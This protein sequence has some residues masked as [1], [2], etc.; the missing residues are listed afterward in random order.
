MSKLRTFTITVA[1]LAVFGA[2]Y[3]ATR[4]PGVENA[5]DKNAL[6]K[7]LG[8]GPSNKPVTV[9]TA[10]AEQR[11]YPL[12]LSANGVISALNTVDVR[13]QVNSTVSKVHIKEGQFVR[14]GELL[15]TLDS[16]I[17]EVN[18]AK[19]QA[20]LDKDLATLADNLR[21]LERNKDLFS[22]KF[23]AQSMVDASQTAVQAQQAVIAS[24]KA[25]I[26]AARVA[27]GYNKILAPS[28]GRTGT[29]NVFA[30]SS[31]QANASGVALVTITQMDPIAIS[32]PLPQRNLQDA[33][34][35]M[36]RSDSFVLARLP[37]EQSQFKG[38]LQFVDN[39]VDAASGTVKVKALFENKEMKLWPGAYANVELSVLTL[40]DAIVVPQDGIIIG[41][42]ENSVYVVDAE[43][44]AAMRKVTLLHSYG[45][46]AVVSG[47]AAG[48]KVILDGKQNL[49][50]GMQVKERVADAKLDS[51]PTTKP[52]T[53][54]NTKSD[55]KPASSA[56][57]VSAS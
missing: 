56:A 4:T 44:K 3:Y 16:R 17:D 21:N 49:R 22:K 19:A 24:D 35:S 20:Q 55:I 15:F 10:V 46:D 37:D 32:F 23:L 14:S 27:L 12:L 47:I 31:V 18:L 36:K 42:K 7:N 1:L 2:G 30:G 51:K 43:G 40:K 33:L 41:P 28:S 25:A 34:D 38:R 50:P 57:S 6:G 48:T 52:D 29:I 13:A 11:D 9:T 53:N 5:A 45:Q 54:L 39:M 8:G 26:S